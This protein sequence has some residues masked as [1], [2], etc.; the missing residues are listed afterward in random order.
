MR[1][2]RCVHG[3]L[4]V[5]GRST[6]VQITAVHDSGSPQ[7]ALCFKFLEFKLAKTILHRCIRSNQQVGEKGWSGK[8]DIWEKGT[9]SF[10]RFSDKLKPIFRNHTCYTARKTILRTPA[11]GADKPVPTL[12]CSCIYSEGERTPMGHCVRS[13][14][15]EVK[16]CPFGS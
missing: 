7:Q 16:L 2:R 11:N 15:N 9:Q 13:T 10:A 4:S 5:G 14:R 12:L 1:R 8:R 6:R 3:R